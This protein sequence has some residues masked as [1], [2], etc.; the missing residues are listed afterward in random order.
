MRSINHKHQLYKPTIPPIL[1]IL[2]IEVSF[3]AKS[4][5]ATNALKVCGLDRNTAIQTKS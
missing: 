3:L 2:G 1:G 4:F 5:H